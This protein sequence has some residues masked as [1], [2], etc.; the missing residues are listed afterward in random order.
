[1]S[2]EFVT[3]PR[4]ENQARGIGQYALDFMAGKLGQ[5]DQSVLRRVEQF[6][7]DSIACGVSALAC[8]ANAPQVLRAEALEYVSREPSTG[9]RWLSGD[10]GG[11]SLSRLFCLEEALP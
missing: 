8:R 3:L 6:H 5:P 2:N 9:A 10:R 11:A 4:D 7:L 1:M